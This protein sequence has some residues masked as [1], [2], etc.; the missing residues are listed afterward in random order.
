[1]KI[2]YLFQLLILTAAAAMSGYAQTDI[3]GTW[4]T[5]GMSMI[6]DRNTVTGSVTPSNG[7][8]QKY[9]FGGDGRFSFVGYLQSTQYGCTTALFND[10]QGKYSIEGSTLTLTPSKNFWRQTFSC[11][12]ASNKERNYTLERET[13]DIT[14][15][16]DEYGKL[17]ICL[18]NEKGETCYRKEK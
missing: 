11:S 18:A 14:T 2:R 1:M 4:A 15:K 10:K 9:Q 5:G 8:T 12:P 3:N 16:T 17:F 13:Y 6:G 7:N